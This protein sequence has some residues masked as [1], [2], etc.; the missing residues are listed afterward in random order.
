MVFTI[1]STPAAIKSLAQ[2]ESGVLNSQLQLF[3]WSCIILS[4]NRDLLMIVS[5]LG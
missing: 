3:G 1:Q 5:Y 4:H 2:R